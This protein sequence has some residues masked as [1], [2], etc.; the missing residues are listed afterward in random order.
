MKKRGKQKL[1]GNN[2]K[3]E[4]KNFLKKVVDKG[5]NVMYNT[6]AFLMRHTKPDHEM[7]NRTLKK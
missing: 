2:G 4:R 5:E 3:N 7:Q 1:Y 6:Q